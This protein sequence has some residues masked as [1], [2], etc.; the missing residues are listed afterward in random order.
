MPPPSLRPTFRDFPSRRARTPLEATCSLAVIHP[1]AE[2]HDSELVTHGFGRLPRFRAVAWL[3]PRAMSSLSRCR[4]T[5]PGRPGSEPRNRL[6]PPA[7][8][9]SKLSSLRESVRTGTSCPEPEAVPLLVFRPS[10]AFS[11]H[12]LDPRP[13]RPREAEHASSLAR[14]SWFGPESPHPSRPSTSDARLEGPHGPSRRVSMHRDT[15]VPRHTLV[16][17]FQSPSRPA[18][19][20]PRRRLL[21]P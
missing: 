7:S 15:N 16:D 5:L 1:R 19:T 17:S 3:P 9:A 4:D 21:L 10:E 14:R 18:C 11:A 13:A 2:T 12:A 8:P 6:V 20:A